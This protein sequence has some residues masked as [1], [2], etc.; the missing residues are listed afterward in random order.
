MGPAGSTTMGSLSDHR[1][2]RAGQA[3]RRFTP[4]A[5]RACPA[6]QRRRAVWRDGRPCYVRVGRLVSNR[7]RGESA[8]WRY[9]DTAI[10]RNRAAKPPNRESRR[11]SARRSIG[12]AVAARNVAAAASC[13]FRGTARHDRAHARAAEH[14]SPDAAP[15]GGHAAASP[16]SPSPPSTRSQIL[17]TRSRARAPHAAESPYLA[18]GHCFC[19]GDESTILPIKKQRADQ[20]TAGRHA[21]YEENTAPYAP[22]ADQHAWPGR[23]FAVPPNDNQPTRIHCFSA[24]RGRGCA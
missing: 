14:R 22:A 23:A 24:A 15:R 11:T 9:G 3:R 12:R 5:C 10:R 20:T 21:R 8:T 6:A 17:I 7:R 4:A 16:P 2:P 13:G 1:Q 19:R 18:I